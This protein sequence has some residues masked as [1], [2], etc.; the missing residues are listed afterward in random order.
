MA[1]DPVA[2]RSSAI[3]VL[4]A[5]KNEAANIGRCIEALRPAARVIVVDSGSTDGTGAIAQ[6]LGAEVVQFAYHGGY[7][8]K[9]QWALERLDLSTP[10]VLLLDADEVV[11]PELWGEIGAAISRPG[12]PDAY[13]VTKGFHFLGRRFRFGGFSHAAVLLFRTGAASFER[14]AAA[15]ESGL[16]MEVHERVI[17]R[18]RIGRLGTPLIHE[19]FKGLQAYVDRHNRYSTWEAAVRR[20]FRETGRFGDEA[21]DARLFGNVQERRRWLKALVMGMPCEHWIWFWYHYAIRL[22]FLEGMP[23]LIACRLRSQ[24]I[25]QVRAKT[26]ESRVKAIPR[27]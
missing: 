14:L 23:G 15:E 11:P 13:F 22:G 26:Y 1:R 25:A 10:W 12:G 4:V 9:R 5:T 20:G 2:D 7:P 8:K 6:R 16:D 17:V 27:F 19:D 3:T 18:G 21:V 24:Y